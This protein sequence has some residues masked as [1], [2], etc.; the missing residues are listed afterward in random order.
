[1]SHTNTSSL[2]AKTTSTT[3]ERR[4]AFLEFNFNGTKSTIVSA[5]LRLYGNSVTSA[6]SHS[7]YDLS[8]FNIWGETTITWNNQPPVG[9]FLA[10][11]TV[12]TTAGWYEFD[13]TN[14]V[15][16]LKNAF[17]TV[18]DFELKSDVSSSNGPSTF[19]SREGTNKPELVIIS[20]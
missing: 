11:Q 20:K 9:N 6:K 12:G 16:T 4:N 3:G 5:K 14:R 19:H 1:M 10:S 13:V 8:P 2:L 7:V 18:A 17:I 15:S